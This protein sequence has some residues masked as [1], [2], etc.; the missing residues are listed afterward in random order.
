M[1][2]AAIFDMDGLLIDSERIIMQGCIQ[3]AASIG[4]T[5]TQAEYVELVGRIWADSTRLMTQQL[6]SEENFQ[7]VMQGL[8]TYLDACNH[9]FPL[10][11]GALELLKYY[12]AQGII[13][14][15][16]SSSPTSHITHRL[17][18]TGVLDYFSHVTSGQEVTRGKP[19]PD[20]YLLALQKLGLQADE[21]IAFEDSELGAQ[22]AIA[23]G[24][25]VVV[26]PDLRQPSDLVRAQAFHVVG[27]LH[28]WH[29]NHDTLMGCVAETFRIG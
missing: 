20:I 10:K 23:A 12:Q 9:V 26:V 24:L 25:R 29:Q 15:V 11:S 6:G 4:I 18:H 1:I 5:Y 8:N 7:H 27:S 16:A 17:T 22:A 2:K 21:C 28:H 14:S 19:N 3:A 13:C